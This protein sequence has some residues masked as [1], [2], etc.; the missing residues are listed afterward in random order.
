MVALPEGQRKLLAKLIEG[1]GSIP[2]FGVS[3]STRAALERAGLVRSARGAVHLTDEGRAA[4]YGKA[5]PAPKPAAT[6]A[7]KPAP[8]AVAAP[9]P[10]REDTRGTAVLEWSDLP[11]VRTGRRESAIAAVLPQLRERPGAWAR[12]WN[13]AGSIAL[14]RK[15]Y[16]DFDFKQRTPADGKRGVWAR[17]VGK[18]RE[19][20]GTAKRGRP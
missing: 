19:H 10:A 9:G 13:G 16:P 15:R 4:F 8:V 6:A 14:W 17:F 7:P 3:A 20:A 12:I 11:K 1:G 5:A 18:N 2:A